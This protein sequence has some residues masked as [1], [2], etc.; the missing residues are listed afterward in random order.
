MRADAARQGSGGTAAV[1][2]GFLEKRVEVGYLSPER[3][4]NADGVGWAGVHGFAVLHLD[5]PLRQAPESEREASIVRFFDLVQ[6][7]LGD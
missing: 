5:G 6:R 4:P 2:N 7:G 1:L 3:R